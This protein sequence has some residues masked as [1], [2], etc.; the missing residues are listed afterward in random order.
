MHPTVIAGECIPSHSSNSKGYQGAGV[1][2]M[3]YTQECLAQQQQQ[4]GIY[5]PAAEQVPV[6]Q[7]SGRGGR[8]GGGGR[9]RGRGGPAQSQHQH[10]MLFNPTSRVTPLGNHQTDRF[11]QALGREHIWTVP[12]E[13][14]VNPFPVQKGEEDNENVMASFVFDLH[15]ARAK[16]PTT[17]P[18]HPV[19]AAINAQAPP[20]PAVTAYGNG[21]ILSGSQEDAYGLRAYY[22]NTTA[23]T[24]AVTVNTADSKPVVDPSELDIDIDEGSDNNNT[25]IS[26]PK[27]QVAETVREEDPNNIDLD[28]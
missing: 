6:Q 14:V 1:D 22:G 19:T 10:S 13:E 23:P 28:F 16:L 15:A 3:H 11:L 4:Q 17:A 8:G 21:I 24:A 18:S 2:A 5:G 27:H 25:G 20:P 7:N 9:G 12:C 26:R